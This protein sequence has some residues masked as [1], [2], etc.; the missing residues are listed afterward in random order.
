VEE[1]RAGYCWLFSGDDIMRAGAVARVLTWLDAGDDVLICRHTDCDKQMRYLATRPVMRTDQARRID[2]ADR[3]QRRKFLADAVTTEALFSF[4]SGLVIRRD[5]WLSVP[6]V[7]EF[8][9]SC[10]GHVARLLTIAE[11][12][13]RVCYVAE[14][15]LDK[16]ADNDSFMD[17]GIVNRFRI[18]VDG[19]AR[20]AARFYGEQSFEAAQTRR[21]MRNELT[22]ASFMAARRACANAPALESR[23]ELDRMMHVLYCGCTARNLITRLTY[24]YF[25]LWLYGALRG[26]VLALRPW[27]ARFTRSRSREMER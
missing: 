6:A 19:Y 27:I 1:A 17:R 23:R 26:A 2:F 7:E 14:T 11:R 22:I 9:G 13:L 24:R 8:T 21:F 4:M 16:R 15:W 25:P 10:W 18:A 20:L 3:Q 5:A 12:Q